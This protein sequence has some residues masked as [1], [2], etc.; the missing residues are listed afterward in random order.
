MI[1]RSIASRCQRTGA[2][3][4][5]NKYVRS[6]GTGEGS[7]T[8]KEVYTGI[9][10]VARRSSSHYSS[11]QHLN[12]RSLTPRHRWSAPLYGS[13]ND[14]VQLPMNERFLGLVCACSNALP[15]GCHLQ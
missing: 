5:Y 10:G 11:T 7:M 4:T 2:Y 1:P 6:S 9:L 15:P 14:E 3:N 13:K 8:W 12:F